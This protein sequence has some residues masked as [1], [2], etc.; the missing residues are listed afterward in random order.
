M[1]VTR[2]LTLEEFLARPDTEPASEF[3]CGEAVQKPMP[4]N[5][6]SI[7]QP[8]IWMLLYQFLGRHPLGRVRTEWRCIFGPPR[9]RR[10]FVPDVVYASFARMPP[11]EDATHHPYLETAPDLA[12]EILSPKD[13]PGRLASKLRFY[14]LHGVGLVWVV[15]PAARTITVY[16]PGEADE[17]VLRA[18]DTL[19]GGDVLPGFR[20]EVAD[21]MAQLRET[22]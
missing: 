15:D 11:V 21:I 18:G 13:R 17:R 8:Y 9:R 12:V 4:T 19:D 1:S 14:L 22:P 5:A 6:H 7:L 2:M 3:W 16:V 10:A 20:A